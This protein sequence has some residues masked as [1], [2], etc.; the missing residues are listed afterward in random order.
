MKMQN[1]SEMLPLC[2]KILESPKHG[3]DP[4]KMKIKGPG[5]AKIE[6]KLPDQAGSDDE[7]KQAEMAQNPKIID[8]CLYRKALALTKSG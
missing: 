7:R 4:N 8:K 2:N 6:G 1:Y 5:H 3:Y